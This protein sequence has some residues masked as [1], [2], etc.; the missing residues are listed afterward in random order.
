ME[1][2]KKQV[3]Q[4]AEEVLTSSFV[5]AEVVRRKAFVTYNACGLPNL[6]PTTFYNYVAEF[7][8]ELFVAPGELDD[9]FLAEALDVYDI[10]AEA[11]LKASVE[12]V[13]KGINSL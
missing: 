12:E 1:D 10:V 9:K 13:A 5:K 3:K 6:S 7:F 2:I 11:R 4:V 8:R